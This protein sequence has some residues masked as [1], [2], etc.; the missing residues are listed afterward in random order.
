MRGGVRFLVENAR[1]L[2][3]VAQS[4][5]AGE[6]VWTCMI[7][8]EG[9]IEMIASADEPLDAMMLT[10]GA[11]AVWR[12]RRERGVVRVEGRMGRVR[13]LIE[14]PLKATGEEGAVLSRSRM[15]ELRND[16]KGPAE[17]RG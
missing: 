16:G 2:A 10:R 1:R 13:C 11:R 7:G 14:Q 4:R 5:E 6:S 15:Y 3:E 8:P 12:V 17:G 9:G